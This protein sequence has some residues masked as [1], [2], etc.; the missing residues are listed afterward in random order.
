MRELAPAALALACACACACGAS[1]THARDATT[2]S[3][4][5]PPVRATTPFAGARFYVDPARVRTLEA[6]AASDPSHAALFRAAEK[7]PTAIWVDS[8]AHVPLVASTLDAV[9]AARDPSLVPVFVVYDLPNRDCAAKS[10]A[11][12]LTVESGGEARYASEV[13]DPIAAAFRAHPAIHAAVIVEPDS[14]ANVATNLSI[15][16]CAA[17]EHAYRASIAYAVRA[18]A[19][20][21]VSVYLDA[22]HSGWL[23][24]DPNRAK[25][26]KIFSEVLAAAGG[27]GNVRGFAIDVSGYGAVTGDAMKRL[28]PGNPCDNET[29]Y[30]RKLAADL[31][32]LGVTGEGFVIDTSRAGVPDARAKGGDWCNVK[33]AGL[34]PRP[35]ADPSP[36]VDAYLWIKP[37]G[38]SDGTTDRRSPRYD[39]SCASEDAMDRAPEAGV[40]FA[41]YFVSLAERADPPLR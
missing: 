35:E 12:E 1:P 14:L 21:N 19:Q 41:P 22:A 17:S 4:A 10:S 31:A 23:G 37:P 25:I 11:G 26:A 7:I 36:G 38:D 28:A 29:D 2:A 32:K 30:A 13:V 18:F 20:P 33:N 9:A 27:A 39:A 3:S 40:F 15:P 5:A 34:G 16:K 24:W 6:A 8:I